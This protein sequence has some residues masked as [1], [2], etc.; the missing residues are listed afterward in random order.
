[1]VLRL[2]VARYLLLKVVLYRRLHVTFVA[3]VFVF[4]GFYFSLR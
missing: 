4:C 1:M 2:V 3:I